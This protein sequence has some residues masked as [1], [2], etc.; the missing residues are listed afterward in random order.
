M[1]AFFYPQISWWG[2]FASWLLF[3]GRIGLIRPINQ[4]DQSDPSDRSD[5]S[6]KRRED[7]TDAKAR[8]RQM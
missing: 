5:R 6:E 8:R 2:R 4:T 7:K 1:P 3:R